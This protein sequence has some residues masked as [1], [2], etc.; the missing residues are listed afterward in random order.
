MKSCF[1]TLG[2]ALSGLL[3]VNLAEAAELVVQRQAQ[4]I[5]K[6]PE[7]IVAVLTAYD[8][9]CDSG[10]RFRVKGLQETMVVEDIGQTQ[11][12]WQRLTGF[13]ET[14]QFLRNT[15]K[16]NADG[17]IT[18][19]SIYPSATERA[20]LQAKTGKEHQSSFNTLLVTWILQAN[21]EGSEAR[22]TMTVDHSLPGIATPFVRGAINDALDDLFKNFEN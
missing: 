15:V 20:S 10:C 16:N 5:G 11:L 21:A 4:V 12:I 19:T 7:D 22:V 9:T 13:K 8:A 3:L 6:T 14:K 18:Y 1:L 2:L 17:S